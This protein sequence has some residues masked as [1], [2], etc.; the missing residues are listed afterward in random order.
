MFLCGMTR[1]VVPVGNQ[2]PS[3]PKQAD[4]GV[5][6]LHR[7]GEHEWEKSQMW[8][9]KRVRLWGSPD[10]GEREPVS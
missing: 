8:A 5:G 4:G 1:V 10:R 9:L 2:R 3:S 6:Y 7:H